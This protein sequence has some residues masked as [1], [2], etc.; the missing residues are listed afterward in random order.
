MSGTGLAARKARQKTLDAGGA[1]QIV[2]LPIA[3]LKI[4]HTYQRDLI[5]DVVEKIKDEWDIVTAGT[6]VVA[7]RENGDL[8]VVDGQHRLAA[9]TLAG[10]TEIL[11][12]LVSGL[13]P[14]EEAQLRIQ[15]NFKRSD[16]ISEVFRAR[17][18]A[19]DEVAVGLQSLC[20][21]Y[22]TQINYVPDYQHGINA[23][24]ACESIYRFDNGGL[25][26]EVFDHIKAAFG[27]VEG[28]HAG[29]NIVK[30]LAWWLQRHDQEAD[31]TRLVSKMRAAG[32]SYIAR[33]ARNYKAAMGG[34]QW[35]NTYRALV[36]IYNEGLR[37]NNKLE[38]RT[39]RSSTWRNQPYRGDNN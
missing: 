34:S 30:A 19:G 15:G 2:V 5:A 1:G 22:D 26:A 23:I 16:R 17:V 14:E 4:D 12:Q 3:S 31:V 32:V 10:E 35:L 9:A 37:D 21:R 18:F 29:G 20:K 8:Y 25:L 11:A 33:N 6:I 7:Q 27:T 38:W 39:S 24:A 28:A 13:T 36:D